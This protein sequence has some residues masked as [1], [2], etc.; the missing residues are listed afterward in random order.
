M[1]GHGENG[2]L[3]SQYVRNQ[4]EEIFTNPKTYNKNSSNNNFHFKEEDIFTKLIKNDYSLIKNIILKINQNLSHQS[5]D[6][7][8]SGTTLNLLILIH[9]HVI[10][11]N[12]GDSRSIILKRSFPK[13]TFEYFLLSIDHKPILKKEKERIKKSGFMK[14]NM[15]DQVEFGLKEKII[16][17]LQL[18]EVLEIMLLKK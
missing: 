11:V 13:K 14:V 4:I 2:H 16:L 6:L 7:D 5:F 18:V 3:V 17:E 8:Y 9:L 10:S 15:K 12:I 1:D